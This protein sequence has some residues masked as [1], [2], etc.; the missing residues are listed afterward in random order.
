MFF[1][2]NPFSPLLSILWQVT[3]DPKEFLICLRNRVPAAYPMIVANRCSFMEKIFLNH[4]VKDMS[5]GQEGQIHVI[6]CHLLNKRIYQ[7]GEPTLYLCKGHTWNHCAVLTEV[8]ISKKDYSGLNN[9]RR[10]I[11]VEIVYMKFKHKVYLVLKLIEEK[12]NGCIQILQLF[13]VLT[14]HL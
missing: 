4:A 6:H 13:H 1:I 7:E 11:P 9:W 3:G 14:Q 5:K 8:N 10:I 2:S 12:I